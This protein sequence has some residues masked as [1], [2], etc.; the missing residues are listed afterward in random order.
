MFCY[1]LG[2]PWRI[3]TDPL[4]EL[5]IS[6]I[7]G[8]IQLSCMMQ[9]LHI[10]LNLAFD[11]HHLLRMNVSWENRTD[12]VLTDAAVGL[13]FPLPRR[14]MEKVTIPHMIYNNNPSSDPNRIVPRLE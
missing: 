14:N 11:E 6:V 4:Q 10:S 2:R 5:R 7:S 13:L 8:S 12:R 1:S 3:E 9:G